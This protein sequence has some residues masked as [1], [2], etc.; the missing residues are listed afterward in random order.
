MAKRKPTVETDNSSW[1]APKKKVRKKRKPMTEEQRAAAAERLAKAREKRAEKNP[2][3]GMSGIHQSIRN[4]PEDHQL[5]PKKVKQWIKTQKDLLR[6]EKQG[7]R[8]KVKGAIAR[9]AIHEAYIRS[10]QRYLRDGD[11][12]DNFYG[13]YQ[14]KKITRRCIA[15]AYYWYGPKKGQPKFDVG[16][17]YPML[18]QVYTQEMYDEDNPQ[19]AERAKKNV[20]RKRKRRTAK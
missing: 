13:E 5:H 14:E 16:V 15:Q 17:Y 18:G 19:V 6:T 2:D 3:Y 11:W 12:T 10:C 4:L 8:Q 20:G 9:A 1:Q 7:V